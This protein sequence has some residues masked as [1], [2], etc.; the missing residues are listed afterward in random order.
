M[1]VHLLTLFM[2]LIITNGYLTS[3]SLKRSTP[4]HGLPAKFHR[5]EES[6][7]GIDAMAAFKA[8]LITSAIIPTVSFAA[9]A[10]S[11]IA[12]LVVSVLTLIP[13][14]YY[15]EALKPKQRTVQQIQLDP[16]TGKPL[17]KSLSSDGKPDQARATK[18]K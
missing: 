12:P 2:C 9:D 7:R 6:T 14:L 15:S 17:Q 3:V 18:K 13:F 1:I 4:F 16:K 5:H 8:V 10:N 11:V